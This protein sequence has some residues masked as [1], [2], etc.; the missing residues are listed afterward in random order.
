MSPYQSM[1]VIFRVFPEGDVIALFPNDIA[2]H[3]NNLMSYMRIVQ[4]GAASPD[5][6]K[7][8]RPATPKEYA[9][10]LSELNRIGYESLEVES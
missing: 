9:D 1:R 5:L 8:L 4:H 7:E 10:L 3:E 2:D 6:I